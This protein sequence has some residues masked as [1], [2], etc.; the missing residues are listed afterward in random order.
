L[1]LRNT[2]THIFTHL[3][4]RSL[5]DTNVKLFKIC[6][7]YA[8]AVALAAT[9]SFCGSDCRHSK[10][11]RLRRMNVRLTLG[12]LKIRE[13]CSANELADSIVL[14]SRLA[15]ASGCVLAMNIRC[16]QTNYLKIIFRPVHVV[17]AALPSKTAAQL[18]NEDCPDDKRTDYYN[19]SVLYSFVCNCDRPIQYNTVVQN[20]SGN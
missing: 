1:R 5:T 6:S 9:K 19:S 3:L 12:R 7:R 10:R 18:Y 2:L 8:S 17:S 13:F 11:P 4:I 20:N 14:H 16:Q 15:A